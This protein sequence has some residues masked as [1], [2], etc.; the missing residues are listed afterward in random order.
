MEK[1]IEFDLAAP[2]ISGLETAFASCMSLVRD[3]DIDLP[4]LIARLTIGPVQAWGLDANPG[5]EGLGT[6]APGAVGDVALLDPD[7]EWTVEPE[8]FV[9]LGQNTPLSRRT[10]RGRPIATIVGGNVVWQAMEVAV[11]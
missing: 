3:G 5:L 4:T 10:M 11:L 1:D 8:R 7:V 6:L 2:G 9:S